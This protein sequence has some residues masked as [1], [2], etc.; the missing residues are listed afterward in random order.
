M[1]E[2]STIARNVVKDP[3]NN[4]AGFGIA[5]VRNPPPHESEYRIEQLWPDGRAEPVY[6]GDTED[7]LRLI[8]ELTKVVRRETANAGVSDS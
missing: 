5:H 6:I 3:E 2:K 4:T 7:A 1:S 8:E